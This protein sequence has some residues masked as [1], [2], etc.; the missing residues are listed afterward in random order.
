MPRAIARITE[1]NS[2]LT[3]KSPAKGIFLDFIAILF[4]SI[5]HVSVAQ[6]VEHLPFKQRVVGSIPTG[7]T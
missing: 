5:T 4:Y 6:S 1:P 7:H 2:S 3:L